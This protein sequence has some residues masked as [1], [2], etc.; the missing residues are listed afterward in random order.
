MLKQRISP[1]ACRWLCGLL[2]A[3]LA[4]TCLFLTGAYRSVSAAAAG[5]IYT[6]AEEVPP[7]P[8]AL[9]FGALVQPDG[10]PSP[11]VHARVRA[12]VE[13]YRAGKVRKLL[14]SGDNGRRGYDEPSGM[15]ALAVR[16]GVPP[17]DVVCDFAGFR[18]YDSCYRARAIF[19]VERAVLVSQ[20]WHLPRALYL[21]RRLGI[22]STGL[23][24]EE[25]LT[26]NQVR[27]QRWRE[28]L[29]VPAAV[30]DMARRR[31]PRF[32]GRAETLFGAESTAGSR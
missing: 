8:V 1:R 13:L 7:A 11:V 30:L 17:E 9:V 16:M 31:R 14:V 4:A 20:R 2:F 10:T 19:G 15:K 29:A 25:G 6:R 23:A 18:T 12:A 22:S 5:R 32:L 27:K 24:A 21:A 26:D 28:A 3:G